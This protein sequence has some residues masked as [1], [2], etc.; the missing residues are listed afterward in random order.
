MATCGGID[1]WDLVFEWAHEVEVNRRAVQSA[2]G[3]GASHRRQVQ[4][5]TRLSGRVQTR[6]WDLRWRNATA[7][8]AAKLLALWKNSFAGARSIDFFPP[9]D[10]ATCVL[11]KIKTYNITRADAEGYRMSA[12]VREAA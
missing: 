9:D 7:A 11:A 6:T 3:R 2:A 8:Q 12:T 10:Q 5:A 1:T 4:T